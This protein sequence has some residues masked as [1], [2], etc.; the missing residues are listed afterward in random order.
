MREDLPGIVQSVQKGANHISR[1][2]LSLQQFSKAST[3]NLYPIDINNE[4]EN[5]LSI[6]NNRFDCDIGLAP[7]KVKVVRNYG[8]VPNIQGNAHYLSEALIN[9]LSNAIESF[10][11]PTVENSIIQDSA[12]EDFHARKIVI[13][14]KSADSQWIEVVIS[15]NG[16]GIPKK[17]QSRVF[18]PFFTTK[19]VGQ[20]IGMGM[21]ISYQI[22]TE[23]HQG[24][25]TCQSEEGK[26]TKF[27]I[28]LPASDVQ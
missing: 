13:E 25:L 26:G 11:N 2:I 18:D 14:T 17:F 28:C 10:E 21:A 27:I 16:S 5:A 6:V 3:I 15:D 4:L 8:K 20:G 9:I 23:H 24:Q 7:Y 19:P 22:V 1:I 12:P